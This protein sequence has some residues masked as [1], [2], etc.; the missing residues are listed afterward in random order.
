MTSVSTKLATWP[1]SSIPL[2]LN[3]APALFQL[4][5]EMMASDAASA[6][7]PGVQ[8]PVVTGVEPQKP[9]ITGINKLCSSKIR[10]VASGKPA[11]KDRNGARRF[12]FHTNRSS[13]VSRG[14]CKSCLSAWT[15]FVS[16]IL[17]L[18][19]HLPPSA[20][21]KPP[22]SRYFRIPL[23]GFSTPWRDACDWVVD[24]ALYPVGG[25]GSSGSNSFNVFEARAN[26][27][28]SQNPDE[29]E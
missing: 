28:G 13:Y 11:R 27:G 22:A 29:S 16:P 25:Y 24:W 2:V 10:F 8:E 14:C 12:A 19:S 26:S 20:K 1:S 21:K 15:K 4:R 23:H 5:R 9:W 17:V 7:P 6:F 3:L 18:M